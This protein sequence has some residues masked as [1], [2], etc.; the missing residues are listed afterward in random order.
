MGEGGGGFSVAADKQCMLT[1][2]T[3]LLSDNIRPIV[4]SSSLSVALDAQVMS[5]PEEI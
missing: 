5:R 4:E 1:F 2:E 3:Y